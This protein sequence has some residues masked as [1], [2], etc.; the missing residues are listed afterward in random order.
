M[1]LFVY[2]RLSG[3]LRE[4][5]IHTMGTPVVFPAHSAE[6]AI[7]ARHMSRL[8]RGAQPNLCHEGDIAIVVPHIRYKPQTEFNYLGRRG[9]V[10]LVDAI[11]NLFCIDMWN[12]LTP[13]LASKSINSC[14]DHWC[15][16]RG[17]SIENIEAVRQ[18]FYRLRKNYGQYNI[19]LG[20]K[21]KKNLLKMS[22]DV[23]KK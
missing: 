23:G 19:I 7:L 2:I 10:E 20:K 4:W 17:I 9:Q 21:Y 11:D 15:A 3:Y 13:H 14:I 18:R 22:D 1:R 5:L 16:Q 12:N 8:P 6:N